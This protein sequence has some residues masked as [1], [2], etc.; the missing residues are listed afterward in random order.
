MA[1]DKSDD[2]NRTEPRLN[3][4]PEFGLRPLQDRYQETGR[5]I[6]VGKGGFAEISVARDLIVDREV[7]VKRLYNGGQPTPEEQQRFLSE[8]KALIRLQHHNIVR[9][10]DFGRDERGLY[11]VMELIDGDDLQDKVHKEGPLTVELLLQIALQVCAA[12]QVAHSKG[13]VHRDLKPANLLLNRYDQVKVTDFGLARVD[14]IKSIAVPGLSQYYASPEQRDNP[15]QVDSRSDLF[16]LGATLYDLAT[17]RVDPTSRQRSLQDAPGILR[18]LLEKLLREKVADRFQTVDELVAEVK[19]TLQSIETAPGSKWPPRRKTGPRTA[20]D[21]LNQAMTA[22]TITGECWECQSVNSSDSLFCSSCRLELREP[23]LACMGLIE[24]WAPF[25]GKCGADQ[26][27]LRQQLK[28][29]SDQEMPAIQLLLLDHQYQLADQQLQAQHAELP[30]KRLKCLQPELESLDKQLQ[31]GVRQRLEQAFQAATRWDYADALRLLETL[32]PRYQPAQVTEWQAMVLELQDLIDETLP[33]VVANGEIERLLEVEARLQQLQ[34]GWHQDTV[35]MMKGT[36]TRVRLKQ[37]EQLAEHQAVDA[38]ELLNGLLLHGDSG[39][40]GKWITQRIEQAGRFAGSSQFAQALAAL[41][42]LPQQQWP[43]AAADW[44]LTQAEIEQLQQQLQPQVRSGDLEQLLVTLNRLQQLQPGRWSSDSLQLDCV[45]V[46]LQQIEQCV[47][48]NDNA[49]AQE[50]LQ[51]I[52]QHGSFA[53]VRQWIHQRVQRAVQAASAG[54]Y[55]AAL[56][57]LMALPVQ[58]WPEEATT[59]RRNLGE[60][61][62]LEQELPALVAAG[63]LE[64]LLQTQARLQQLQPRPWDSEKQLQDCVLVILEHVGQLR[65]DG[66]HAAAQQQLARVPERLRTARYHKLLQPP[67]LVPFSAAAAKTAQTALSDQSGQAEEW[68]NDLGMKFRLIPGGTFAM[69]SPAGQG[70]N[71]EHP[72]HKV[73]ISRGFSLGVHTVT[74]GQWQQLMGTTPWQGKDYVTTGETIAA[75]YVSW[76]DSV[77]FCQRLSA[78]DGRRYRLPTEAEWEWSCRAGTTTQ[79][80]CGDDEKQLGQYAWYGGVFGETGNC[81]KEQYAHAVGQKLANPFGLY[82]MH[83]NVWEWCS[84]W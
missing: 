26:Q 83:G 78:R 25:C 72:Q 48:A 32:P 59:W 68:S 12:L 70:S 42:V 21:L 79:Y 56:D 1:S 9:I 81:R 6:G 52:S 41:S 38:R 28:Q 17:G 35:R 15:S 43:A 36:C 11:L 55:A 27:Q 60:I 66:Q 33:S 40:V 30:T 23:C 75:T 44:Q 31:E 84:D 7:A 19:E 18:P 82:D 54:H 37:V 22:S 80:S 69:G 29:Q 73:T 46:R 50:L 67:L 34:P 65:A 14:G 8:V 49:A 71:D 77:E 53:T 47:T 51:R 76:E 20:S 39:P 63:E 45:Q 4:L 3:W 13:I 62:R 58:E 74:Q 57:L 2:S 10:E 64:K 5:K 24:V 16:S 61:Q